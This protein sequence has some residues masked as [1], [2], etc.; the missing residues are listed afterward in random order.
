VQQLL[1][2]N[3][4]DALVITPGANLHYLTGY[5]GDPDT[6]RIT[7]LVVTADGA[8]LLAPVLEEPL[9]RESVD[10][11]SQL[12]ITASGAMG[13]DSLEG[14]IGNG[15]CTLDL[16]NSNGNIDISKAQ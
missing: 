4:L 8:R 6:E 2:G 13:G 1:Q 3:D 9:A 16:T 15:G 7:A 11:G 5:H 14:T 10:A 12:P